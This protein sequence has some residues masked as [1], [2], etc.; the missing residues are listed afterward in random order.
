MSNTPKDLN[1]IDTL[2]NYAAMH[3]TTGSYYLI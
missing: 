3:S 1:Q 2:L